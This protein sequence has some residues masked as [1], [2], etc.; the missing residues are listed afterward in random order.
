MNKFIKNIS[1]LL[2]CAVLTVGL[3]GCGNA[4]A[5]KDNGNSKNQASETYPVT[6]TDSYGKEITIESEPEKVISVA[7]NITEMIFKLDAEDKLVGRTD[8]CDYPEEVSNIESIGT[9]RTPDIEKI[10][11][12][13]PDLVITSTHFDD[14]NTAKLEE[15]GID[16]VGLYEEFQVTGVY[17]MLE[18]LGTALNKTEEAEKAVSEMKDSI[19]ETTE[20]VKGLTEPTVYYVV[21]Y[22]DS[23]DYSAPANTFVGGLIKLAGG[24][25][26]VPE[27]DSWSFSREALLEADPEIIVVRAGQKEDFMKTPGYEDLTAVKEGKVYEID[28]NLIDR[29]GYRNAEGVSALAKIF[30]PEAF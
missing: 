14:E 13:E 26:I 16:V 29:Q 12:L 1:M 6:I 23:G 24:N 4:T 28:N 19:K 15:A 20:A 21:G 10:I 25:N 22:G 3:V 8:Y 7:P 5:G 30:H 9:L 17:D 27:S 2:S 18:T 11:S